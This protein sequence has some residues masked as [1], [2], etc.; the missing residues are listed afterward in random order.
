VLTRRILTTALALV[1]TLAC[2]AGAG[3]ARPASS[4]TGYRASAP[5][6]PGGAVVLADFEYPQAM[7]P[8]TARTD[9]DLRL[10]TLLFAPLWGLGPRLQPYPDLVRQ[11]PTPADGLVRRASDGRSTTV[12]VRLVP[13]LRWSDGQP[14]TAD[15]VV[16][17]WQ[18][19]RDPAFPGPLPAGL[20]RVRGMDRRSDTEVVWTLAGTVPDVV[21]LGAD[22]FPLPAHRLRSIP[23]AA[24]AQDDWFRRPDVVSGPFTV[25]EAEPGDHVLLAANAQYADGRARR[26]AYPAGD[27][28]F[29][30]APYL[31]R[32][33]LQV[34]PSKSVEVQSLL[35]QGVDAGFHLQPDDVADLQG[36]TGSAPVV[37][38][39]LRDEFLNP[40]HGTDVATGVA[41][42]WVD[43]PRVLQAL[44]G[45][46]DRT[47]LVRDLLAGAGR[48][49]RG[50]YPR[51]L[52]AF[53]G[54]ATL[55]AG[56]GLTSA[57]RLLDAAGWRPGPDGVRVRDGRRLAFSLTGICGRAGVDR[58]LDLL[59]RQWLPL[60][61]AV[62][63]GCLPQDV[64]FERSRQGALDM[65]VYSNGWGAD[66]GAWA[67]TG[68]TGQPDNWN[69][70]QDRALDAAF[71]RLGGTLDPAE[72]RAAAQAVEREWLRVRCTV[73]LF[74]WPEVRQVATRLRNFAPDPAAADSWNAADWW[75]APA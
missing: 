9:A 39:G 56:P 67:S 55:P 45:A 74:E 16:F 31:E 40:N 6:R 61:A 13:G 57:V 50:L 38:T 12:D 49:A 53:A 62:T 29:T 2:T 48:P 46:L 34:P 3:P 17:T 42:P 73:P 52:A 36:A 30:H 37:T 15:D 28:P 44:D 66:P 43:D 69:R 60:G 64:L 71:A 20:D 21:E 25:A 54:G 22:L 65:T 26:G 35:A 32:V 1:A 24:W 70:C 41:P 33:L 11:V 18:A 63:T 27:G 72:R 68:V 47:A 8:L 59:R 7:S 51:A 58:E 14:I 23:V 10:G 5:A 4:L 75:L 19:M